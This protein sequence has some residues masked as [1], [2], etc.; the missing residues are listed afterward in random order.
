MNR[1]DFSFWLSLIALA[2]SCITIGL[3]FCIVGPY[4]VIDSGTFIGVMTAFIGMSVTLLI[5]YQIYNAMEIKNKLSEMDKLQ[6]QLTQAKGEI[7]YLKNDVYD[8]IYAIAAHIANLY[9]FQKYSAFYYMN[10]SLKYALD[11]DEQ[12]QNYISRIKDIELY[13][14][15]LNTGNGFFS[16]SSE[17]MKQKVDEYVEWL[18]PI[19]IDIKQ[20]PKYHIIADKYDRLIQA[21]EARMDKI[22]H[23]KPASINS[24]YDDLKVDD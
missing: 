20:H 4:S 16:G 17:Q 1:I 10:L 14:M 24:I 9:P 21:Y 15:D 12:R 22:R 5:G 2:I 6:T 11:L 18:N 23:S 7:V 19:I 8:G 13:A 3:F